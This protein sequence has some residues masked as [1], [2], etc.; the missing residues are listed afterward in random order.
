MR[1]FEINTAPLVLLAQQFSQLL[2]HDEPGRPNTLSRKVEQILSASGSSKL[3]NAE[4]VARQLNMSPRTLH[5]RLTAEHTS[6]QQL[7]DSF[8][9]GLARHYL[10]RRELSIDAI[11]TLMGFQDNSA[12]YRSFRKWTGMSPGEYRRSLA[13]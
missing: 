11:A 5:R 3:P 9:A 1:S 2:R 13:A 10:G 7:K 4:S 8:R 12:F 6:F